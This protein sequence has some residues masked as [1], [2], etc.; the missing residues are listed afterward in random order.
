MVHVQD[1]ANV[2]YYDVARTKPRSSYKSQPRIEAALPDGPSVVRRA[3]FGAR[4]AVSAPVACANGCREHAIVCIEPVADDRVQSVKLAH[5]HVQAARR[6]AG[7]E[8]DE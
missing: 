7:V 5:L 1:V 6:H 8:F 2:L 4:L 3:S